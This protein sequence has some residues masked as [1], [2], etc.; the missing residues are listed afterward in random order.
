MHENEIAREHAKL[1][2]NQREF[3]NL[4]KRGM[5]KMR[6][7]SKQQGAPPILGTLR[8]EDFMGDAPP[9]RA[10]KTNITMAS[11]GGTPHML[12]VFELSTP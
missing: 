4:E 1:S 3:V 10:Q 9:S 8:I 2:A 6:E 5:P 7:R 12:D 11:G